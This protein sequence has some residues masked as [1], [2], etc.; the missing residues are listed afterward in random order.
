MRSG[1]RSERWTLNARQHDR[2]FPG[3]EPAGLAARF[4]HLARVA[5]H[6]LK[7]GVS[8]A[9]RQPAL[10]EAR[11]DSRFCGYGRTAT[12]PAGA[13]WRPLPRGVAGNPS[14]QPERLDSA[15]FGYVG[16]VRSSTLDVRAFYERFNHLI[17][18]TRIIRSGITAGNRR[19]LC[20][21]RTGHAFQGIEYQY[22]YRNDGGKSGFRRPL[23]RIRSEPPAIR[24]DVCFSTTVPTSSWSLTWLERCRATGRVSA[25]LFGVNSAAQFLNGSEKTEAHQSLDAR[26]AK[27][28]RTADGVGGCVCRSPTSVRVTRPSTTTADAPPSMRSARQTMLTLRASWF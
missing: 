18:E 26:I 11:G 8:R 9:F 16:T 22:R 10:I 3:S 27:K 19:D 24:D 1:G 4:R 15:E 13:C 6:A 5:Q 2:A 20:R 17:T 12:C 7:A 21:K 14:L 23:P 25:T 28:F